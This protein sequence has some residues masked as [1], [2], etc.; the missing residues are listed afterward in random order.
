MVTCDDQAWTL[1]A[2]V[3]QKNPTEL[4][5]F[6]RTSVREE[7]RHHSCARARV[8][9]TLTFLSFSLVC[10]VPHIRRSVEG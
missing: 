5:Y 10:A 4:A 3:P 9:M 6:S 2:G 8:C 1:Q 7:V